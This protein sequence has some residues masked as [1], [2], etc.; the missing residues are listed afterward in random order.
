MTSAQAERDAP[1][2]TALQAVCPSG[3]V[4]EFRHGTKCTGYYDESGLVDIQSAG[5]PTSKEYVRTKSLIHAGV[6]LVAPEGSDVF[7]IA[8]GTVDDVI[9]SDKDPNFGALGYMLLIQHKVTAADKP[10]YSLYLHLREKP[11]VGVGEAVIAGK[12]V[13]GKVG[14]TGSAFGPNLH[15]E[16]RHFGGRFSEAWKNIYGVERPSNEATFNEAGFAQHWS[17]PEKFT[18]G[19]TG[20]SAEVADL[21]SAWGVIDWGL[22]AIAGRDA[23]SRIHGIHWKYEGT[24]F[25]PRSKTATF[26]EENFHQLPAQWR[27]E[28]TQNQDGKV[29]SQIKV[30]DGSGAWLQ[31]GSRVTDW[32]SRLA[33]ARENVYQ[34]ILLWLLSGASAISARKCWTTRRLGGKAEGWKTPGSVKAAR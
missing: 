3:K 18:A 30:I 31:Q 11:S 19:S 1:A 7:P 15:V 17:D 9:S 8:D 2:P 12:T 5:R 14:T 27:S 21:D 6:D 20:Q 25:Y 29:S 10:T 23:M 13:L 4:G 34:E 24:F 22:K 28:W 26:T 33:A 32:T 16:V